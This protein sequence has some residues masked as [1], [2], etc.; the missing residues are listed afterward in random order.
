MILDEACSDG[1]AG[2]DIERMWAKEIYANHKSRSRLC[3][4][5]CVPILIIT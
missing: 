3:T 2:R 1:R 4:M 5:Y